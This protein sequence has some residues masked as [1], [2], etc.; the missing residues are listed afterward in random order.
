MQANVWTIC[1]NVCPDNGKRF[2]VNIDDN[3]KYPNL[4]ISD[5]LLRAL[6]SIPDDV[7][8]R[9]HVHADSLGNDG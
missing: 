5:V 9:F 6:R 3:L 2:R 1:L 8:D 4:P 7:L